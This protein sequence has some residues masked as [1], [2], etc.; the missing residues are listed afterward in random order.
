[1]VG[2]RNLVNRR[3][4]GEPDLSS[5]RLFDRRRLPYLGLGSAR[6]YA[7]PCKPSVLLAYNS[8]RTLRN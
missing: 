4:S 6:R 5:P 8:S 1:M 2:R 7:R 3:R